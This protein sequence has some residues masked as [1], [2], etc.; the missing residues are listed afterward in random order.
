MLHNDITVIEAGNIMTV[1]KL[2]R[3]ILVLGLV[4]LFMDTSSEI[5]HGLLP[6]FL[7]SVLGASVVSI[8]FL[9]G[10]A[11]A[12]ALIFKF[13]SGPLSDWLGKRKPFVVLGY[14]MGAL[15]KPLF[16]LAYSVPFV[17][18]ARFVDRMGKGIR[19]APRDALVAD[20][21]PLDLR[22]R[23][24]GLRQ[25]LDTVGAF[26]GPLLAIALMW[27]TDNDYR[28][29]FWLAAIPGFFAVGVLLWGVREK[30]PRKH[31][32][33]Y[34]LQIKNLKNFPS[35]F[36]LVV[37]A[38][39]LFQLARFSEA[40]LILRAKDV[41][42]GI[43]FAPLVLIVM[44]VVYSSSAYPIG[45]FSDRVR[46]DWFLLG[47]LF[48][49]CISDL[50][51]GFGD[52]LTVIFGGIILWGLHLGLTQGTLSTLVADTCPPQLRGTAYGFFNLFSAAALL[53]ASIVAGILWDRVGPKMTFL[54]GSTFSFLSF[55]IFYLRVVQRQKITRGSP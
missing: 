30:R 45:L 55:I 19:G 35:S 44:N 42:L 46:R 6:V 38:G 32:A 54:V 34:S 17:F 29:V 23:A 2:P 51:L 50:I 9:E 3:S 16:A 12:T 47:G 13:L 52:S 4:S 53:M 48:V 11:E 31:T 41:G 20:L 40:F 28:T 10:M 1:K 27:L 33:N 5:I 21:A 26:I 25:S 8:G 49:L 37:F 18:G 39:A 36:W 14:S 15:S 22:G 43:Q 7:V 24:F